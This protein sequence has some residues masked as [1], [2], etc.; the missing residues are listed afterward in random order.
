MVAS[1]YCVPGMGAD[2]R[3]QVPNSEGSSSCSLRQGDEGRP[4]SLKEVGGK[5]LLRG[6]RISYK[7]R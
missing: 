3:V 7:A 2:S 5:L 6:T 1:F 4:S